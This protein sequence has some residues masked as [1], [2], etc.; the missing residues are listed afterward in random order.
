MGSSFAA[1]LAGAANALGIALVT[2]AVSSEPGEKTLLF[3]MSVLCLVLFVL[4]RP[5]DRRVASFR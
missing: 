4:C 5:E 2:R 3:L 1:S